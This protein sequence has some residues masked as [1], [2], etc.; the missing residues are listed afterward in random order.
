MPLAEDFVHQSPYGTISGKEAYLDLV[1]EHREAFLGYTFQIHDLLTEKNTGCCRYSAIKAE[2][3]MEVSEW[4]Y[5]AGGKI[6]K[7]VAY[8]D[9]PEKSREEQ[10]LEYPEPQ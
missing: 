1:R 8:Y 7:V 6:S 5:M 10:G 2:K 4:H 3:T 9:L